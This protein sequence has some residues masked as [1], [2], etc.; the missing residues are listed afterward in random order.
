MCSSD[1]NAG[2][3]AAPVA[4]RFTRS[5][6]S[7]HTQIAVAAGVVAKAHLGCGLIGQAQSPA[8]ARFKPSTST[9]GTR[10]DG[11]WCGDWELESHYLQRLY[12]MNMRGQQLTICPK[13]S[14]TLFRLLSGAYGL[15]AGPA[16][17]VLALSLTLFAA[18]TLAQSGTVWGWG[19]NFNGQLGNG[20]NG[21]SNVPVQVTNLSQVTA[22]AGGGYHSLAL[23]SDGTVWAWGYNF[24]GQLGDGTTNDSPVP[25]QV[26]AVYANASCSSYLTGVTAIAGGGYH[27]LALIGAPAPAPTPI[28]NTALLTLAGMLA[29]AGWWM[30]ERQRQRV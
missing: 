14:K 4:C 15:G 6:Q 3:W 10:C 22:I 9:C 7:R 21:D 20:T 28:S 26:C 16:A 13:Q 24:F 8:W 11:L 19:R 2:A 27:S 23:K 25:V 17:I 18:P 30:L 29:A 1:L 5:S 12:C